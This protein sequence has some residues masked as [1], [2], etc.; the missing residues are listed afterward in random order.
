DGD[1]TLVG[2]YPT[3][4]L[5]GAADIC[6]AATTV[7]VMSWTMCIRG[8]TLAA[9]TLLTASTPL[10]AHSPWA[11]SLEQRLAGGVSALLLLGFWLIYL[12]GAHLVPPPRRRQLGFHLVTLI[13]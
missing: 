12:R 11:G 7:A 10:L 9:A 5:V 6:V 1:G 2:L 13:C 4:R 3:G 8:R